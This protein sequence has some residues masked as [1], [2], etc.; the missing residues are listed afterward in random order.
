MTVPAVHD[1]ASAGRAIPGPWQPRVAGEVN[2]HQVKIARFEGEFDW[3][4]HAG[5]DE[6]FLVI[7]GRIAIDL[8]DGSL[9]LG[10]GDFV[11][12]P[13]GTEHRPRS[14]TDTAIVA[15]FEPASTINTGGEVTER[16]RTILE[17]LA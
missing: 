8:R 2:G 10:T 11:V 15:M 14:L 3:H 12:V 1:L 7:E 6:G 4:S 16:T 5:E 9:E 17:K 13:R